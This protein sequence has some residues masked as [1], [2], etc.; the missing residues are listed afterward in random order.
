MTTDKKTWTK[1]IADTWNLWTPPDRPSQGELAEYEAALRA[2]IKTK[3]NP[4]LLVLGSTSEF[5]DLAA[6]YKVECT[7][8]EYRPDNYDILGSL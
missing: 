5:R 3:K 4:Q 1:T 2:I 7:V 8:V 6:R